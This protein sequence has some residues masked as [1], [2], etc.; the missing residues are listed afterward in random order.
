MRPLSREWSFLPLFPWLLCIPW[1]RFL[2]H[3]PTECTEFT[4]GRGESVS[5]A[6]VTMRPVCTAVHR[7]TP[8]N[9]PRIN[10]RIRVVDDNTGRL[11][12][13]VYRIVQVNPTDQSLIAIDDSGPEGVSVPWESCVA[14]TP[15]VSWDWIQSQVS[16]EVWGVLSAFDGWDAVCLRPEV[17]EGVLLHIRGL[18]DRI[19]EAQKAQKKERE[20]KIPDIASKDSA[21][22][23][24]FERHLKRWEKERRRLVKK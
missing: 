10:Q 9:N 17:G 12:E 18:R 5:S 8:M 7:Y 6:C 22:L 3:E 20:Q 11:S 14:A 24:E 16:R 4:E 19:L 13:T 2:P 1:A 15:Q 21:S 23:A